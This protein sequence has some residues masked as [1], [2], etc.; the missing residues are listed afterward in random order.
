MAIETNQTKAALEAAVLNLS[1]D[2]IVEAITKADVD[3]R[4]ARAERAGYAWPQE[5]SRNL[6]AALELR[7]RRGRIR[8]KSA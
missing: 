7:L 5:A 1:D 8:P 3:V 2:Q 6:L 4:R